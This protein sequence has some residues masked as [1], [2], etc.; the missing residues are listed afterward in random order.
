[1]NTPSNDQ[2]IKGAAIVGNNINPTTEFK[3]RL[4]STAQGAKNN[5]LIIPGPCPTLLN[6]RLGCTVPEQT[7]CVLT[8]SVNTATNATGYAEYKAYLAQVGMLITY[9]RMTTATTSIYD[10]SLFI[11]ELPVNGRPNPEEINLSVYSKATG[12][13]GYDKTLVIGDRTISN[14]RNFYMYLSV[15][16]A[17][18]VLDIAF[19]VS[20]IGNS[21]TVNG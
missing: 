10:G 20:N 3:V 11:G 2:Q 4:S 17:S 16:P 9:I 15:M 7:E 19:G 1:M 21:F 5:L 13:G 14:T 6:T 18:A 8:S 12:G